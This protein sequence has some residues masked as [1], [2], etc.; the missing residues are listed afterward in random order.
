MFSYDKD[1]V[2]SFIELILKKNLTGESLE[3]LNTQAAFARNFD[4]A[5]FNIVFVSLPRKTGKMNINFSASDE[6]QL[7]QFRP[8]VTFANWTIDRLARLWWILQLPPTQKKLYVDT[9][10]NL[11]LNAEMN[12]LVALYSA[13]PFLA[14]PEEWRRRCAEG[15]RSN[16]GQVL[17]AIMCNNPYASEQLGE[18]AWNQLVLKAIFTEK[19]LLRIVGLR[20]R[21]NRDLA[22]SISEF[23]HERWAAH[24]TVN[25]LVWICVIDFVD[26]IILRDLDRLVESGDINERIAGAL[27]A[28]QSDNRQAHEMV[29]K[30]VEV[31]EILDREKMSW[32]KLSEWL[33][34]SKENVS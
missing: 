10:E 21:A 26:E 7:Q 8:Q 17:E 20:Q 5:K 32:E 19:P 33:S 11:F 4:T 29:S 34:R 13:L 12:E 2:T 25:P 3:W 9:I 18:P 24:R 23:A 27:A 22:K 14:H 30:D 15:I 6:N 31:T 16:I 1:G 28:V